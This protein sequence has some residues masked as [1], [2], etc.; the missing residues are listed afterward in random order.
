MT[1]RRGADAAAADCAAMSHTSDVDAAGAPRPRHAQVWVPEAGAWADRGVAP[2][3]A[4]LA[5]AGCETVA[6]CEDDGGE[7]YVMFADA[8]AL[9]PALRAV[10]DVAARGGRWRLLAA[11]LCRDTLDPPDGSPQV[12][13]PESA[14]W[15]WL[16]RP[17]SE[18]R[19]ADAARPRAE[20]AVRLPVADLDAVDALRRG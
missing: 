9:T 16:A 5:D 17:Q 2:L 19:G 1:R 18:R 7:A 13:C 15:R 10:A 4:L 8:A 12:R 20:A 3:V 14:W 6:S 11:A